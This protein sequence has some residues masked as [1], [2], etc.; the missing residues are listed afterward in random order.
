MKPKVKLT[1]VDPGSAGYQ[2]DSGGSGNGAAG[3]A[4]SVICTWEVDTTLFAYIVCSNPYSSSLSAKIASG[5]LSIER[6]SSVR[7]AV[8]S[9]S[10]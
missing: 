6:I 1:S 8:S 10:S 5:S 2:E 7:F 4:C 9:S 3:T